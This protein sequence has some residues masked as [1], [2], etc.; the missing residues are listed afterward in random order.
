MVFHAHST[1]TYETLTSGLEMNYLNSFH[2]LYTERIKVIIF[3]FSGLANDKMSGIHEYS[4]D[5]NSICFRLKYKLQD[6]KPL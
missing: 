4:Q 1:N 3:G 2:S 5:Q 6:F